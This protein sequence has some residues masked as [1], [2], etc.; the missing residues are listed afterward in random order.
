[1]QLFGGKDCKLLELVPATKAAHGPSRRQRAASKAEVLA[2][3][4]AALPR[5]VC[6]SELA[7]FPA[8]DCSRRWPVSWKPLPAHSRRA[9]GQR[10][11]RSHERRCSRTPLSSPSPIRVSVSGK[12]TLKTVHREFKRV[13]LPNP[14]KSSAGFGKLKTVHWKSKR[15][16]LPNPHKSYSCGN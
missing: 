13:S 2:T 11:A 16:S 4:R 8:A 10:P 15:V 14:M 5:F 7:I 12:T 9:T 6:S 1:M 3:R